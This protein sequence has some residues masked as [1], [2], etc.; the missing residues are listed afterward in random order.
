[1]DK[2]IEILGIQ[3]ALST[4]DELPKRYNKQVL[5]AALRTEGNKIK[6]K[7][8]ADLQGFSKRT[9]KC[10]KIWSAKNKFGASVHVGAKR[11]KGSKF[12]FEPKSGSRTDQAY[13]A[14]A[15]VW[16]E[17]GTYDGR[18]LP[19]TGYMRRAV[20]STESN[21]IRSFQKTLVEN[22]TKFLRRKALKFF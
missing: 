2:G 11:M 16:W 9:A 7:A 13:A 10:I 17:W 14:M 1:M 22:I 18:R 19:A 15:P 4:L 20:D 6:R 21:I 12:F 5:K 8:A 3:Q